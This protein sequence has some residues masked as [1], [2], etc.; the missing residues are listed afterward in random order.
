MFRSPSN[1]VKKKQIIEA[2]DCEENKGE[3]WEYDA[4]EESDWEKLDNP[5]AEDEESERTNEFWESTLVTGGFIISFVLLGISKILRQKT[6]E[7]VVSSTL[8]INKDRNLK[9]ETVQCT[10]LIPDLKER[11]SCR[12]HSRTA[13]SKYSS[14]E[15][16]L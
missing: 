8:V 1:C 6:I 14:T 2:V 12:L 11:F 13:Y 3:K 15:N 5:M 7:E 16:G 10:L 9:T 4:E